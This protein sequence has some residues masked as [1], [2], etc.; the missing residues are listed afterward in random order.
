MGDA[1]L[2]DDDQ[3]DDNGS[4]TFPHEWTVFACSL[5]ATFGYTLQVGVER[6]HPLFTLHIHS[7]FALLGRPALTLH[8]GPTKDGPRIAMV[9]DATLNP[10]EATTW[11]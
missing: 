1:A 7:S 2:Y 3:H 4:F 8:A 11:T 9:K 6:D 5:E 10:P